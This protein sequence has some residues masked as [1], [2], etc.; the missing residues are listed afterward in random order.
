MKMRTKG[1]V[2]CKRNEMKKRAEEKRRKG[3]GEA[4]ERKGNKDIKG[5]VRKTKQAKIGREER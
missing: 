5:Q 4:K 1:N 3:R 2:E